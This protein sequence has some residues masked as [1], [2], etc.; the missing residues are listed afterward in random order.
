[1]QRLDETH[2]TRAVRV[3]ICVLSS[4]KLVTTEDLISYDQHQRKWRKLSSQIM[5]PF[6]TY[7]LAYAYAKKHLLMPCNSRGRPSI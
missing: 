6:C 1:M 7:F 2:H 5:K 4:P 3:I